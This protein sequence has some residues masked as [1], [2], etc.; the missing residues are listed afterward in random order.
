MVDAVPDEVPGPGKAADIVVIEA[1]GVR[2]GLR[3]QP[4]PH[5]AFIAREYLQA[6]VL[7]EPE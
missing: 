4:Q 6:A 2:L 7:G 1:E 3:V 5:D